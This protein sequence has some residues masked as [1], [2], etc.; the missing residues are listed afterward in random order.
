MD[1]SVGKGPFQVFTNG[2]PV[3]PIEEIKMIGMLKTDAGAELRARPH[4]LLLEVPVTITI[5]REEIERAERIKRNRERHRA[6]APGWN[7]SLLGMRCRRKSK[8]T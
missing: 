7:R 8:R 5:P 1:S 6:Q 3:G 4:D 2:Q